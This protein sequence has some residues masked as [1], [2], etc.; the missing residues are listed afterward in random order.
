MGAG[1]VL[2]AAIVGGLYL[3]WTTPSS[4]LLIGLVGVAPLLVLPL[5]ALGFTSW[6]AEAYSLRLAGLALAAAYLATFASFDSVVG[7]GPE[8]SDDALVVYTHNVQRGR[9]DPAA[10]AASVAASG[11]DVVVLQ[12]VWSRFMD[13]LGRRPELGP[14]RYR[15]SEPADDTTG[16]AVWSRHP[17]TEATVDRLAG[18]PTLRTRIETPSGSLAL[19]AVHTTA[20]ISDRFVDMWEAQLAGLAAYDTSAP[21]VM[22]GDFNATMD[23]GQFRD[24]IAA[25]WT[26]AHEPKGCGFDATW[27][28][29]GRGVPILRLDHVLVTD[30]FDVLGLELGTSDG[31]DHLSVTATIRFADQPGGAPA[32]AASGRHGQ[33]SGR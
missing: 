27:P 13:E 16:L 10:V 33:T 24:L 25:G 11:A 6:R 26:D 19:D 28:S 8:A 29:G 5:L 30:H 7:C 23:H 18:V 15:T 31:S 12:E 2:V 17:I 21:A 1:W 22:A 3:R 32:G 4:S 20:P 14:Y 9:G